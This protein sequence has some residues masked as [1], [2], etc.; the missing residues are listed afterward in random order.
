MQESVTDR[1]RFSNKWDQYTWH[2]DKLLN[3]LGQGT[4]FSTAPDN[5]KQLVYC[6]LYE[7]YFGNPDLKKELATMTRETAQEKIFSGMAKL[8]KA[9]EASTIHVFLEKEENWKILRDEA[10]FLC[11]LCSN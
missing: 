1:P 4:A 7:K 10:M 9:E 5:I 11:K 3:I 2:V 6:N 8:G